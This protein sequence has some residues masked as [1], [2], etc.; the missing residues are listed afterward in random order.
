MVLRVLFMSLMMGF[1]SFIVFRWAFHHQGIDEARTLAFTTIVTFEWFR[2]FN[3][4]SDERTVFS[5]GLLRNK[6][7]AVSVT[8]A[9]AL[10][11]CVIYVPALQVSFHTVALTWRDWLIVLAAGGSLF[12]VEELRK[13][14]FPRLF[15]LGK[16]QPWR[17]PRSASSS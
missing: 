1:G 5:L 9:V 15:S 8:V 14:L 7:L 4:R 12:A 16:W 3:A 13:T 6:V 17:R 10:Q 2:A 11:A